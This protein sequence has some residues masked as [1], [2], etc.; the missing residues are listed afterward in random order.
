MNTMAK[1]TSTYLSAVALTVSAGLTAAQNYP[2]RPLRIVVPIASGSASDISARSLANELGSQMGQQI[3]ID[4]RPGAS[5]ILGYE[6]IARAR[7]R[8]LHL[9]LHRVWVLDESKHVFETSLR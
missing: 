5:G 8:W 9:G 2:N 1:A 3:V 4:N 7:L 6:V